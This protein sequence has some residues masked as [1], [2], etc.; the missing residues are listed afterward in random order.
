MPFDLGDNVRLSAQC[1]NPD[2]ALTT[3]TAAVLT[4]TL[5]DGTTA[6]PAIP[7]PATAGQYVVDYVPATA[8]LHAVRWQFTNPASAH[9]DVI[10]VRPAAPP[11]LFS[12][13]DAK[14]HLNVPLEYTADDDEI[15]EHIDATTQVVEYFVGAVAR[16]TVTEIR[17]G[18]GHALVLLVTPVIAVTVITGVHS[19]QVAVDVAGL[20]A[21]A[22]TGIVRRLDGTPFPPGPYRI[23]YTAGRPI[24][25]ANITLAGRIIL[26]HLWRT[27]NGSSRVAS[28]LGGGDD[29]SVSE[30]IPGLGYAVPNRALELLQP[31]TQEGGFA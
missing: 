27:Q 12:L 19:H 4:I 5:P 28:A 11:A 2:G 16:R 14:K 15:R 24:P 9:T 1:R 23:T 31:D 18:G 8:G 17:P 30:P 25:S 26:K 29:Y 10:D 6:T 20:V 3:A 13:A 21:D 7:A 22:E